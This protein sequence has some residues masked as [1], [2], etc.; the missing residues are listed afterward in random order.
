M[1]SSAI[2]SVTALGTNVYS[3][4]IDSGRALARECNEHCAKLA[5]RT[6][7][8]DS[9]DSLRCLLEATLLG[10]SKKSIMLSIT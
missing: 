7:L 4:D 2:V 9:N 1:I 3:D 10:V 5:K 6:N 8:R